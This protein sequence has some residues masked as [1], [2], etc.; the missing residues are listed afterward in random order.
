VERAERLLDLVAVFLNAREAIAWSEIQEA[1][2]DDYARG[3]PEANIRKFERDKADLAELGL[4]LTYVQGED[5]DKDGYLLD[6][7]T[8]YLPTL[9]LEK[10]ELAVL[11]AAGAAA[12]AEPA[13]PFRQ[14]L[15]HALEK[16]AFAAGAD[17]SASRDW[18][19]LSVPRERDDATS[20]GRW[21]SDLSRAVTSR[22]SVELRYRAQGS[23]EITR[24]KV[25]PYGLLYRFG[26]WVLVGYCHLR[27]DL[28]TFR[29]DR[30]T[31]LTVNSARPR[32]TDF[33]VP[34]AFRL[35][36]HAITR[37]WEFHRHP[38][39]DVELRLAPNMAFLAQRTFQGAEVR[40]Q[41]RRGTRLALKVSDREALL[42][43]LLP[44]GAGVEI[45][46]PEKLRQEAKVLLEKILERHRRGARSAQ[47]AAA[48]SPR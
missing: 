16:M 24:R 27:E 15:V 38:S 22:K 35:S 6:R 10:D 44:L 30:I 7:S 46:R 9:V 28:R 45:L 23:G 48:R 13:F 19:R 5:R 41:D 17:P 21:V 43:A 8:Y 42:R 4:T 20:L 33:E 12:L 39:I 3:S 47:R 26:A 2:P 37:P 1:F 25:D 31:A 18:A 40:G 11:Y 34:A 29:V 32:S 36:D 14:D